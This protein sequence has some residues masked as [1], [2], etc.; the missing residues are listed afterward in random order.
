MVD[1]R[2]S[3]NNKGR[4]QPRPYAKPNKEKYDHE[5]NHRD[6][7]N[8]LGE[9]ALWEGKRGQVVWQGHVKFK[10]GWKP[11]VSLFHPNSD[12][13]KAIYSGNLSVND[14]AGWETVAYIDFYKS[15]SEG[16]T[17]A[18]GFIKFKGEKEAEYRV[19]LFKNENPKGLENAPMWKGIVILN[20][21][22]GG[23]V[24][25]TNRNYSSDAF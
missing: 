11:N 19:L 15:K 2:T 14:G 16:K 9:I 8:I 18:I 25:N 22:D 24:S 12:N 5:N 20:E 23:T 4:T 7:S 10:D 6:D 17:K 1:F 13:S 21:K 3:R